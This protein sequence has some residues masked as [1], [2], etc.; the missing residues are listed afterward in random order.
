M[1]DFFCTDPDD[2]H[3]KEL[4]DK[5]RYFKEDEKGVAAMCKVMEDMRNEAVEKRNIEF[6]NT[7]LKLGK[8]TALNLKSGLRGKRHDF[9][10]GGLIF[11]ALKRIEFSINIMYNKEVKTNGSSG[12]CDMPRQKKDAQPISIKMDKA[13][14]DR[15]EAYCERAGQSKTVAIERALN[16]LID[17]YDDMV[18]AYE[19]RK[20]GGER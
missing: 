11:F 6:A 20:A 10:R 17:E 8:L 12:R 14:F 15:L 2:M 19:S 5:V 3:Y 16:K 13:T 18:K 4:A 9:D 1:H 7:L